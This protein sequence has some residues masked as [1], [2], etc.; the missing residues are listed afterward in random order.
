MDGFEKRSAW[1]A[2]EGSVIGMT[3]DAQY[4]LIVFMDQDRE[5]QETTP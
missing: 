3:D 5:Y 2:Q 4:T 1:R